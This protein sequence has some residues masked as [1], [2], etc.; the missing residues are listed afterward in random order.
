MGLSLHSREDKDEQ[1]QPD[2]EW[3]RG[4]SQ[5]I[6]EGLK[7]LIE[8]TFASGKMEWTYFPHSSYP[9]QLRTLKL[10]TQET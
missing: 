6:K 1:K 5:T 7:V 4:Q 9:L 10:Y 8:G 2:L 3:E